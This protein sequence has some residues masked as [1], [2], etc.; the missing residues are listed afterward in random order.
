MKTRLFILSASLLLMCAFSA[1]AQTGPPV[2]NPISGGSCLDGDG[3]W[4]A[5]CFND[6]GPGPSGNHCADYLI[7]CSNDCATAEISAF[8]RCATISD[9]VGQGNCYVYAQLDWQACQ[10]QCETRAASGICF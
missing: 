10:N 4:T 1:A 7:K 5:A 6:G 8:N 9:P 3:D 2:L